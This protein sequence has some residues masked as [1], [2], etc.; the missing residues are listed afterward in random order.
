[1][2]HAGG[3]LL[4]IIILNLSFHVFADSGPRIEENT[5]SIG[6]F[7]WMIFFI[8]IIFISGLFRFS[9][10]VLIILEFFIFFIFV[11]QGYFCSFPLTLLAVFIGWL[12]ENK[13]R[14]IAEN[15]IK[16]P[17]SKTILFAI[18]L[19]VLILSQLNT[20]KTYDCGREWRQVKSYYWQRGG[21]GLIDTCY[22]TTAFSSIFGVKHTEDDFSPK[23]KDGIVI[24]TLVNKEEGPIEIR[25]M[26]ATSPKT[27]CDETSLT[28]KCNTTYP[29]CNTTFAQYNQ[30]IAKGQNFSIEIQCPILG[31]NKYYYVGPELTGEYTDETK[32]RRT[33][34]NMYFMI[35]WENHSK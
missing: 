12:L 5:D 27:V 14:K 34:D 2:K 29:Q 24:A 6:I 28:S 23:I 11:W 13:L 31:G 25:Q 19:L 26:N 3:I 9:R 20:F 7:S 8:S 30:T 16:T 21:I 22:P 35:F 33:I 15:Y 10:G 4:L 18:L 1:M 17:G 32:S